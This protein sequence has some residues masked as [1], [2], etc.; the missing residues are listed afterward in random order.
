MREQFKYRIGKVYWGS[1]DP[2]EVVTVWASSTQ[3]ALNLA[4]NWLRPNH[5]QTLTVVG[6]PGK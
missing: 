4:A 6:Q 2:F 3:E 1:Q 5:L